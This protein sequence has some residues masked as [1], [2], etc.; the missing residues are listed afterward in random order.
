MTRAVR[1]ILVVALI[2][3]LAAFTGCA[4]GTGRF[5]FSEPAGFWAG[6]WH[7]A[8]CVITFII[9]LFSTTV[10]MYETVNRG[11]LYDLGFLLGALIVWGGIFHRQHKYRRSRKE[12]DWDEIGSRVEAKVRRGIQGWLDEH[13]D[14]ER[15]WEEIGR[16][17]EEKIKR[18]LSD[19]A[20]D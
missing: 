18:E 6:L 9:S 7:G 12:R 8:I 4:A 15:E 11:A 17:I 3:A 20:E 10:K 16:K 13:D 5:T 2:A 1:I 19:W 14:S